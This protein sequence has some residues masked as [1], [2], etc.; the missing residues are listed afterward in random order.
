MLARTGEQFKFRVPV[1]YSAGAGSPQKR[2]KALVA[3]LLSGEALPRFVRAELDGPASAAGVGAGL[4]KR[5]VEFWGTP[6]AKDVGELNVGVYEREGGK[7]VGR[8]I[9]EVVER[10]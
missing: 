8:V 9:I 6:G 5:I 4:E 10:S 2:P 3:R 1:S 7:C